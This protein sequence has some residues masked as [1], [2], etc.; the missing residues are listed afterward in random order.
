MSIIPISGQGASGDERD[1]PLVKNAELIAKQ[2]LQNLEWATAYA[3]MERR[4]SRIESEKADKA[5]LAKIEEKVT[6]A[7]ES[8]SRSDRFIPIIPVLE[9]LKVRIPDNMKGVVGIECKQIAIELGDNPEARG[10]EQI[11]QYPTWTYPSGLA[12]PIARRWIIRNQYR[13]DRAFMFKR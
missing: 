10:K 6:R 5:S 4:V 11:G 1:H 8:Q 2:A 12:L 13:P 3:A 9:G 7:L